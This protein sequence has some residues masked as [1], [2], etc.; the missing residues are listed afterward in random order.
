MRLASR[1]W[2][3]RGSLAS[4]S[5]SWSKLA[6]A[7]QAG[8]VSWATAHGPLGATW[9]TLGRTGWTMTAAWALQPDLGETPSMLR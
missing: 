3:G 7:M 1:I 8:T 4:L 9:L 2:E 6:E 5:A